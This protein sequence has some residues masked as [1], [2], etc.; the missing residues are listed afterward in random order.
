M[1]KQILSKVI[2]AFLIFFG[3][4]VLTFVLGRLAPGDGLDT[5]LK[6]EERL[7][8][9]EEIEN[10]REK[11]G[12]DKPVAEQYL[13]WIENV[14]RGDFGISYNSKKPVLHEITIRLPKTLLLTV[15]AIALGLLISIPLAWLCTIKNGSW[16][17]QMIRL[18]NTAV[19]ALPVFCIGLIIMLIF[20][21]KF[22]WLPIVAGEG[23]IHY[24]MPAG[25]LG[26]G[27]SGGMVRYFRTQFLESYQSG[28]IRYARA[29][30]VRNGAIFR[31]HIFRPLLPQIITYVG[32]RFAGMLGGSYIIESMFSLN[33]S[34]G[35]LITSVSTRDYPMIQGY[36]VMMAAIY[37]IMRFVTETVAALFEPRQRLRYEVGT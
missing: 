14:L 30:G 13:S 18:L 21:V 6:T 31:N 26:L 11:L 28:H 16:F 24:V 37:V 35:L 33:G 7:V 3:V 32:L 15:M 20:G 36:A 12:L 5:Y 27:M 29:M 4:S 8:S 9:E 19:I 1:L 2:Y 25:T 17:D 22:Q 10:T 23:I 34:G